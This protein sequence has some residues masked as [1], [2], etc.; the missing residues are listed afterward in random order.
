MHDADMT[1][2]EARRAGL[3]ALMLWVGPALS[4][5]VRPVAFVTPEVVS[6]QSALELTGSVTTPWQA[7]LSSQVAGLVRQV[8]V[9]AGARV[10]A[11]EVLLELDADLARLQKQG[12][13]AARRE[14]EVALAEA[15]RLRDEAAPLA[16]RGELAA[17]SFASLQA[18][19]SR[20]EAALA[21]AEAAAG[22]A[23]ELLDRHQLRA[24]FDG[25]ISQRH[26]APGEWVEPGQA[27]LQLVATQGLRID[28]QVPQQRYADLEAGQRVEVQLQAYPGRRYGGRLDSWVAAADADSRSVLARVL[29]DQDAEGVVPGMSAR[30]RFRF[31]GQAEALAVPRDALLRFPDG[32]SVVWVIDEQDRARRQPVELSEMQQGE[33]AVVTGGLAAGQRV[34]VRGN[35]G[36]REGQLLKP[37]R[38][39]VRQP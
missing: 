4:E 39:E 31:N 3:I 35:E 27:L 16:E 38:H 18:A 21:S 20:A 25:V 28:V 12:A 1:G 11:G 33:Q 13:A 15:R 29:L 10:N 32:S 17:S 2:G 7:D 19:V 34:V 23:V 8:A 9:D 6:P 26:I 37:R 24:P 22:Q 36:L 5:D 30:L 14:A